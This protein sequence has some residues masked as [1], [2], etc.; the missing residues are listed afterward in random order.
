MQVSV[1]AIGDLERR[2]TVQVPAEQIEQEVDSRLRSLVRTARVDGFRPGKVPFKVLQLKY[3]GRVR[4]EVVNAVIQ[5]SYKDALTQ[6]NLRVA[7]EPRIEPTQLTPGQ[8]LKYT[9]L[10]EVYPEIL[11][12]SMEGIVVNKPGAE[13]S[14]QDVDNMLEIL[15]RQRSTWRDVGRAAQN[16]DRAVINYEATMEGAAEPFMKEQ[17]ANLVIGAKGGLEGLDARLIGLSAGA[18]AALDIR[19]PPDHGNTQLAGKS[20]HYAVELVSVAEA[21]VPDMDEE[22]VRSFGI[23][24]GGLAKLRDEVR[25]NMSREMALV[26]KSKVKEQVLDGLLAGNPIK[27]PATLVE[28][29]IDRLVRKAEQE[30]QRVPAGAREQLRERAIRRVSLGLLISELVKLNRITVDPARVRNT[31]EVVASS[32]EEPDQVVKWYYGNR[33]LLS[34]IEA[35]VLEDQVVDWLLERAQVHEVTTTFDALMNPVR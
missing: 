3:E 15:R 8:D 25:A 9:A 6:Q 30:G 16:G 20:I 12:S 18:H 22:F 2:L 19:Y 14:D 34:G 5:S 21:V 29:E 33:E 27:V 10:I 32:Y 7:G 4:E 1:E 28:E 24:D 17:Q 23:P 35:V 31:V 26:I 11:V 13:I